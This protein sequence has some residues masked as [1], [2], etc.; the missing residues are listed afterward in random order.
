MFPQG[1]QTGIASNTSKPSIGMAVKKGASRRPAPGHRARED[2]QK[3]NCYIPRIHFIVSVRHL[4]DAGIYPL[5]QIKQAVG[6]E[7]GMIR[8]QT[9]SLTN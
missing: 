7:G 6:L 5:V 1:C 4:D 8:Q 2:S 3:R 9:P